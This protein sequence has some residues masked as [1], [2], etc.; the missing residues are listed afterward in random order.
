[1]DRR[2]IV[3]LDSAGTATTVVDLA[4]AGVVQGVRDS[5]K[6]T[7]PQASPV[8]A[9]RQR[10][11]GGARTVFETHD[12]GSISET[13]LVAGTSAD[14]CLA[15]VSSV[16]SVLSSARTDLFYEWRPDGATSSVF[17]EVRGPAKIDPSYRWV[18]FAGA[19]VLPVSIEIPVAPLAR[20]AP[21]T[22]AIAST[23]L[24]AVK[25]LTAI[26]G[27]APALA[28]VTLRASGGSAAPVWALF[29]WWQTPTATPLAGSVAPV[30]V[31]EA[32][33]ATGLSGWATGG[34]TA[35]WRGSDGL[36]VTT[37]GAGSAS[38]AWVVDPSVLDADDF[39]LG[40]VDIE[41]WARVAI[42][43]GVVAPR[44]TLS[45]TPDAGTSFGS[46][47]Y[48][49]EYGSAGKL[50]TRPSSGSVFRMVRLGVLTMPVD[51][52]QP[53]KWRIK[54]DGSWAAG[55]AGAFGIDYVVCVPARARACSPSGVAN[56]AY[57]PKFIASTSDT[58][59]TIRSDLS[60]L[61]GSAAANKGRDSGLGGSLIELPPGDVSMLLKLSSLVADDPTSDTSGEQLAHTV[62][63]QVVVWP[64]V[65]LAKGT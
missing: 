35:V 28:D 3:T 41:V 12:N 22:F 25:A 15:N 54:L 27:D 58:S 55:S 60:G 45:L 59:K 32:E 61:V 52:A 47:T 30:G 40:E 17:Y 6:V 56:D 51:A 34:L 14:D 53:V 13:L 11:Y 16:L 21:Q 1:M 23:D 64:R 48:T 33:T 2:R 37:S 36:N 26:G 19:Q 62:T 31:I 50:I 20:L 42:A 38:A 46:A 8:M 43:A 57:F 5:F 65:F 9:K 29:G 24:P 4:N 18:E 49:P 7:M 39:A 63:G 44:L 10:R